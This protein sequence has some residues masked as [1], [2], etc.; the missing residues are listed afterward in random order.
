[1]GRRN[2][3]RKMTPRAATKIICGN[4]LPQLK[5]GFPPNDPLDLIKITND[6]KNPSTTM[7]I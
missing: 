6:P 7:D 2:R 5:W 4:I 3:C 1:M